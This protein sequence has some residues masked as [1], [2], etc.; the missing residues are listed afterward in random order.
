MAVKF[1]A[2][3]EFL[4]PDWRESKRLV[5]HCNACFSVYLPDK[6]KSVVVVIPESLSGC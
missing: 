1:C 3:D 6:L 2:V 4:C 5:L